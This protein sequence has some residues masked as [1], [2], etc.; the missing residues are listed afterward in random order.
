MS[1]LN[2]LLGQVSGDATIQNLA[3]KVGLSPEL[4]ERAVAALGQA[5]AQEGNTLQTASNHRAFRRRSYPRLSG[6]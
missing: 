6:T 4:A 2:S 1:V 5:H 3:E